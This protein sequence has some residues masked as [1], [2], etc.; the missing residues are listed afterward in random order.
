VAELAQRLTERCRG[1]I[2]HGRS[3]LASP[4]HKPDKWDPSDLLGFN[5][6]ARRKE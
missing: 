1:W 6:K 2:R 4:G 3:G 5:W